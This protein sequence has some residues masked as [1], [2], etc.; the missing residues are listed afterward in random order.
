M[1][2]AEILI[3]TWRPDWSR[4][5]TVEPLNPVLGAVYQ[6]MMSELTVTFDLTS[7]TIEGRGNENPQT[8]AYVVRD[9]ADDVLTLDIHREGR[10]DGVYVIK[11]SD[12]DHIVMRLTEPKKDVMALQR[13]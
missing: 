13:G 5:K 7:F 10:G 6:M 2:R 9:E 3:G 1:S 12:D 11:I 8:F 4:W